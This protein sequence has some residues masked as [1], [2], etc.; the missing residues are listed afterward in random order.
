MPLAYFNGRWIDQ[1]DLRIS[2]N[3]LGFVLGATLVERLR[4]FQWRPFRVDA[5]VARLKN[6]L[7]AVGWDAERLADEVRHALEEFP[8]K[9]AAH[10]LKGDDWAIVA[11]VTPGE[12]Y[13]AT[14]PTVAVHGFPLP[15]AGWAPQFESG[16]ELTVVDVRQVP[17][18][19][20]P[21]HVKCRSRMHY[22]LADC[23]ARRRAP[24]TRALLLD[25]QGFIGEAST[26]NVVAYFPKRG[27]VTPRL[28]AVLPGISQEVLFELAEKRGLKRTEADLTPQEF[29]AAE[30]IFLT[31]TSICLLPVVRLDGLPVGAGVP[32]GVYRDLL[33]DWSRAVGVEIAEQARNFASRPH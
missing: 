12:T 31:S 13:D 15:F 28:D 14:H 19:S 5:H 23:E 25:Q 7:V 18:N 6:A 26:A 21:P 32:G 16:V 1:S 11:F 30:E 17:G 2:A 33:A 29:A 20:V 22:Y 24:G 9:N 8:V 3:D 4:T 10:F 27:L